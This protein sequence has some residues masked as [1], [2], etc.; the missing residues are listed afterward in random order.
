M[1]QP[2][3][4]ERPQNEGFSVVGHGGDAALCGAAALM[5]AGGRATHTGGL[6]GPRSLRAA[7]QAGANWV[8]AAPAGAEVFMVIRL[9]IGFHD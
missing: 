8:V 3:E 6:L 5:A 7:L 9:R 2:V 4:A 1:I